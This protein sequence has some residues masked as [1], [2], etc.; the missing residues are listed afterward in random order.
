[1]NDRPYLIV[2]AFVF[3]FVA[4]MHLLRLTMGWTAQVGTMTFPLWGSLLTLVITAAIA[5]WGL[6][7]LRH[8]H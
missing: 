3:L 4:V 8:K 7:L 6:S 1:M 5:I 2:S